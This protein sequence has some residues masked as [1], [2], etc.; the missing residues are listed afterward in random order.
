M[1]GDALGR[2]TESLAGT[3]KGDAP[4]LIF[5]LYPGSGTGTGSLLWRGP[6][7]DPTQIHDA[8]DRLQPPS[9]PLVVRGYVHYIGRGQIASETPQEMAQYARAGRRLDLVLCY[10]SSDGDLA[11]WTAFI[12]SMLRQYGPVLTSLQVTEEPNNPDAATGGDGSSPNVRL[13]I[14]EGVLA[15]KDEVLRLGLPVLIGFNA[16]PSRPG[17]DF[18]SSLGALG[19]KALADA[20]DYVGLD[21]FPDVFR[22]LPTLPNGATLSLAEAVTW[23]VTNYRR[24]NL[25]AALLPERVPIHITEHGWPT[26]AGRPAERQVEVLET[27]VRTLHDMRGTLNIT[28]YEYFDLRDTDSTSDGLQFGLLRDDYAP[29]PAFARYQQLIA[30]LGA[31]TWEG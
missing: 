23:V 19:G 14:V 9:R 18:W 22:P 17:D 27:A 5:G 8:L 16:T 2:P 30:E 3:V 26:A 25:A 1:S 29:K 28:R 10:R 11:D 20:V 4:R 7:D 6:A 12:R 24:T 15:A 21:F 13:A 31:A